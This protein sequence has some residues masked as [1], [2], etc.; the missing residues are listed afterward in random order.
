M[1]MACRLALVLGVVMSQEANAQS[2][3]AQP[4]QCDVGPVEKRY[5]G[6]QWLVYSCRN[7]KALVVVT[8][9]QSPAAPFYFSS[10][11]TDFRSE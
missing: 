4:L 2:E 9:P 3:A 5:G 1:R 6:T 8:A 7:S 11:L 10:I